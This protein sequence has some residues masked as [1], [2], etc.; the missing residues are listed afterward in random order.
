MIAAWWR[1]ICARLWA[2]GLEREFERLHQQRAGFVR[3][4]ARI[5]A[6]LARNE[7]DINECRRQFA[8]AQAEQQHRR[9]AAKFRVE[10]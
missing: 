9:T 10:L 6:E 3:E 8:E 5:D 4:I 1:L 2:Q 7:T